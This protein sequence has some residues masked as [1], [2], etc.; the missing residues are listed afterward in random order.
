MATEPQ[1]DEEVTDE[2]TLAMALETIDEIQGF[3]KSTEHTDAEKLAAIA[4]LVNEWKDVDD[5]EQHS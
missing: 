1:A 3:I 5:D 2:D 4:E